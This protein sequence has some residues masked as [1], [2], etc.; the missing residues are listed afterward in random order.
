M[1][2]LLALR[3]PSCCDAPIRIGE[4][5]GGSKSVATVGDLFEQPELAELLD[6]AA[7]DA[8]SAELVRRDEVPRPGEGHGAILVCGLSG[9]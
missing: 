9:S 3:R 8:H 7:V 1:C 4:R 5:C 2:R 6:L